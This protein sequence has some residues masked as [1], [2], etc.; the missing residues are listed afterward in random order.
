MFNMISV[1]VPTYNEAENILELLER[2]D[3]ALAGRDYEVVVV[4]DGSPD[5]TAE[6][7]GRLA[8]RRSGT[9]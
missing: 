4:D 3:G 6:V 7:T 5:G 1:V 9:P 2:L 8:E